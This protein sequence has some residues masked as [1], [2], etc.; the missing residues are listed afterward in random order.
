VKIFESK[1]GLTGKVNFVDKDNVFVGFDMGHSC[2]EYFYWHISENK[3]EKMTEKPK[4]G[5]EE[6][7]NKETPNVEDYD[8]D[9]A[10]FQ[11]IKDSPY[12]E[13]ESIVIFRLVKEN[14]PDLYLHLCNSHD[15][16]YYHGFEMKINDRIIEEGRI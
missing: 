2:C 5:E 15:G 9:T 3:V 6:E 16:Y 14:Y 4:E 11:L 8:F 1:N 12:G 10:F 13:T 7:E